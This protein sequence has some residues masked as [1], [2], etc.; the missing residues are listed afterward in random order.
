MELKIELALDSQLKVAEP[1]SL[2]RAAQRYRT[3]ELAALAEPHLEWLAGQSVRLG[4]NWRVARC[5]AA[6]AA[7]GAAVARVATRQ[8]HSKARL[9]NL[10]MRQAMTRVWSSTTASTFV[11]QSRRFF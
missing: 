5:Q 11:L 8:T 9:M 3:A 4:C 6:A 2:A 7:R 1:L 10:A